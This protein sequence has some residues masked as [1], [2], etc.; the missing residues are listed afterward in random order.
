MAT[1][2]MSMCK[3]L[4]HSFSVVIV[5]VNFYNTGYIKKKVFLTLHLD[6]KVFF[7]KRILVLHS[8]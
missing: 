1:I 6:H 7:K 8:C 3:V 2:Q 5:H 4:V